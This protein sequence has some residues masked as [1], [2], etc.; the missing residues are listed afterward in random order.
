MDLSIIKRVLGPNP[1]AKHFDKLF[2]VLSVHQSPWIQNLEC[3]WI[4]HRYILYNVPNKLAR[5]ECHSRQLRHPYISIRNRNICTS[6]CQS[7]KFL[8]RYVR[9]FEN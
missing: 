1:P 6:T 7:V 8:P 4:V 9:Q 5:Q 2:F 3:I